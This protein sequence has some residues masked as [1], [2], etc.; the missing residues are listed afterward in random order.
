M[1]LGF[2]HQ[3]YELCAHLGNYGVY[4]GNY[5]TTFRDNLS[6]MSQWDKKFSLIGFLLKMGPIDCPEMSI[7]NYHFY[8]HGSVHRDSVLIRSNKM[9]HMQ[10]FIYCKFTLRV[11]GVH[12]TLH[13]EYIKL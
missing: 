1:T 4:G 5:L 6:A 10:V 7:W 11:S 9:Q 13:Q 2:C 3:V 8:S 12:R